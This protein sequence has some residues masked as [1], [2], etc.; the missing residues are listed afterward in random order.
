MAAGRA[1]WVVLHGR[2]SPP[3]NATCDGAH[4]TTAILLAVQSIGRIALQEAI[5]LTRMG[6]CR[7]RTAGKPLEETAPGSAP[8]WWIAQ[9]SSATNHAQPDPHELMVEQPSLVLACGSAATSVPRK[10][11]LGL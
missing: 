5:G 7:F 9:K 1:Q 10:L 3:A 11:F 4:P 2:A 8:G 6:L